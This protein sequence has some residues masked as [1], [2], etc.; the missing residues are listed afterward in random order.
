MKNNR[1][2]IAKEKARAAAIEYQ[3]EAGE[4]STT[5]AETAEKAAYFA[6]LGKRHGLTREF[7]ENGII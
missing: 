7:K 6:K 5:Y 2:Q 3:R 4:R 1:Y